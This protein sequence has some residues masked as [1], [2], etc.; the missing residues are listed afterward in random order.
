MLSAE[1]GLE[2]N[3]CEMSTYAATFMSLVAGKEYTIQWL[4]I[5]HLL[6]ADT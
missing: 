2:I 6:V 3:F 5:V 1:L 4:P